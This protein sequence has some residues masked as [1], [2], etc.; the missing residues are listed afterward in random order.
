MATNHP[1][2]KQSFPLQGTKS[3]E[4]SP[5]PALCGASLETLPNWAGGPWTVLGD[6]GRRSRRKGS[7]W[8]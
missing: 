5:E 2:T 6:A 4:L 7:V 8:R 3:T 1:K